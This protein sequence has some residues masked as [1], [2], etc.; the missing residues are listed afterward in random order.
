MGSIMKNLFALAIVALFPFLVNCAAPATYKVAV[1]FNNFGAAGGLDSNGLQYKA[2]MLMAINEI[3]N[4]TDGLYDD[5]LPV[6]QFSVLTAQPDNSK[7]SG[8]VNSL[9]VIDSGV[10]ACLGPQESSPIEGMSSI[11]PTNVCNALFNVRRGEIVDGKRSSANWI[12]CP[13]R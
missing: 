10:R 8:A 3:N 2:A 13:R 12:S 7:T 11:Y 4:K 1:M 9:Y 5:I 6:T